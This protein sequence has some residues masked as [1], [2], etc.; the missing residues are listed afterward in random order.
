VATIWP[1]QVIGLHLFDP[2]PVLR[3]VE[4]VP[5]WLTCEHTEAR[6]RDFAIGVLDKTTI[7]SQEVPDL[8]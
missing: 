7:R 3:H 1:E 2:V 6:A 5:S 4:L 8:S